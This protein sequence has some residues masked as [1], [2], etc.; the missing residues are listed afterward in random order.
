[1][2]APTYADQKLVRDAYRA[3]WYDRL[4]DGMSHEEA[5]SFYGD[6][7]KLLDRSIQCADDHPGGWGGPRSFVTVNFET[8][9]PWCYYDDGIDVLS[10]I[11]AAANSE[12]EDMGA[13]FRVYAE[14]ENAAISTIYL[15]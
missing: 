10:Q 7:G 6:L 13:G 9:L 1:M 3:A 8:G 5:T 11:D 14:L 12:L 15:C 2:T 4:T